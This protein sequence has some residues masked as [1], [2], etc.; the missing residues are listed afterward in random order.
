MP[1]LRAIY[2][3]RNWLKVEFRMWSFR[4]IRMQ[5]KVPVG[6]VPSFESPIDAMH[7]SAQPWA[8]ISFMYAYQST[9]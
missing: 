8:H 1:P 3:L 5:G 9:K 7:Q 4:H 2:T 6:F